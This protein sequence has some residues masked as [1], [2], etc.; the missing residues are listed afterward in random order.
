MR[1]KG[2][3]LLAGAALAAALAAC[4]SPPAEHFYTVSDLTA[5]SDPSAE[6]LRIAVSPIVVPALIDRPQLV[7]RTSGH[8]IAVLENHRWAEPLSVDLTRALITDLQ[9]LRP[10]V[11]IVAAG[12][13]QSQAE[14]ILD[15]Q[16]TELLSGP[17]PGTSLQ[18]SWDLHDRA[19]N[20]AGEGSFSAVIRTQAGYGAIPAAYAE[21]M[22][23]LAEAIAKTISEGQSCV[24]KGPSTIGLRK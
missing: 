19:R 22:S 23:R 24:T 8:E 11:D 14:Q 20:C 12:A 3:R 5:A 15:V 21:A 4:A 16:I 9:R 6:A 1:P 18:A 10:G 17:G 2:A 7:V 13:P